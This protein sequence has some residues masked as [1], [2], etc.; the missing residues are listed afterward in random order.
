VSKMRIVIDMQGAQTESRYRGIGRY[1]MAFAKAIVRNRGE[2]EVILALSGLFPE[3]IE[4]IRDAFDGLLPQKNILIWHAPGPVS[5][6]LDVEREIAELIREYFFSTLQA[7]FL[8]VSSLFE[9]YADN[10]VTS[11]G[12]LNTKIQTAVILYDL[13]PYLNQKIYLSS[14]PTY[15]SYYL[16][17]IEYLK[18]ADICF[19]ISNFSKLEAELALGLLPENVVSISTAADDMFRKEKVDSDNEKKLR[20]KFNIKKGIILYTGGSDE[21]KNLPRLIEAFSK[22][23][24]HTRDA[25]QLVFVGKLSKDAI[26]F[27]YSIAKKNKL[28]EV[29]LIFTGLVDDST[30]VDLY[31]I[32]KLFVFPSWHEGFGLPVLEAMYCE[33]PV[34]GSNLTSIPEVIGFEAALFDPFSVDDISSKIYRAL[35]DKN[36]SEMIVHHGSIQSRR[37]SWDVTANRA[38]ESIDKHLGGKLVNENSFL[39]DWTQLFYKKLA[40]KI[41]NHPHQKII[42]IARCLDL[43]LSASTIIST[44]N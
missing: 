37:F 33:V 28:R 6:S 9:G 44:S 12:Q 10:A 20:R 11:V 24:E 3:T 39:N 43:N 41:L 34:L 27:L 21:R 17:K 1:T 32:S 13:I 16:K 7:D 42:E 5:G 23:P 40:K 15:K 2:H 31:N 25:H 18:R 26:Y 30:L 22:L 4:P 35:T 36:F 38:I 8:I 19:S 29:D 14:S